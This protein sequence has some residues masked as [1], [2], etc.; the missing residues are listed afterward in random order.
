MNINKGENKM[1]KPSATRFDYVAYDEQATKLQAEFKQKFIEL[2]EMIERS[3]LKGRAQSLV[4][5][6]LE[7]AYMWVG[8]AVRDEQ[9][10]YR[11]ARLQERRG[12]Q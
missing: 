6:K 10:T 7:E 4:L 5:T 8:K 12:D 1:Q 9:V 3:L 2:D 11:A